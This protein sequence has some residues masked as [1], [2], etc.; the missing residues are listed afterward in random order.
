MTDLRVVLCRFRL[1]IALLVLIT[2]ALAQDTPLQVIEW[3]TTGT[4][5]LRFTFGK[6]N[7]LPGM[8]NMRGYVM[9]TVVENLS[10]R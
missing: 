10:L 2:P 7:Q 3:P 8:S 9:D 6:F 5:A 1:V 4:P